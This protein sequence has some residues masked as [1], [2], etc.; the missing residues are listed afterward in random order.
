MLD[1]E[2]LK[3][4]VLGHKWVPSASGLEER[5]VAI[6]QAFAVI[7]AAKEFV[8]MVRALRTGAEIG[9]AAFMAL[10]GKFTALG[11]ALEKAE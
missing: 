2:L 3:T 6:D 1:V 9:R 11:I 4:R 7:T 8:E 5:E 10:D